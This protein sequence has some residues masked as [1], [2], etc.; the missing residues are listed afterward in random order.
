VVTVGNVAFIADG[1]QESNGAAGMAHAWADAAALARAE[2]MHIMHA[3]ARSGYHGTPAMAPVS[4]SG[5]S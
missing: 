5:V 2:A 3:M 4:G 1:F